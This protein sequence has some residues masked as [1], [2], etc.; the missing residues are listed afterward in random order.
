[1]DDQYGVNW[2]F[3]EHRLRCNGH[4]FNLAAKDF[5]FSTDED[6][7]YDETL[8]LAPGLTPIEL[9]RRQWR[10]KGVLGRIHNFNISISNSAEHKEKW[11]RIAGSMI[12]RDNDTR[13]GSWEAQIAGFLQPKM[14]QAYET[15]WE[16]H[17]DDFAKVDQLS[18]DDWSQL[19]K[20]HSFLRA[21]VDVTKMIE[22]PEA[23]LDRVLPAMEFILGHFEKG[24]VWDCFSTTQILVVP[25]TDRYY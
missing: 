12:P 2:E 15:W 19:E 18:D 17:G 5:L 6:C 20:I 25:R 16:L 21:I 3:K 4:I 14:R 11:L 7:I 22:G 10:E 13:W 1:M 23:T 24:K 9:E 8:N